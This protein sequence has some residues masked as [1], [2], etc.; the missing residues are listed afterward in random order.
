[1]AIDGIETGAFGGS[2]CLS[3]LESPLHA[4]DVNHIPIPDAVFFSVAMGIS[5]NQPNP[6]GEV[7]P[8]KGLT[9]FY[10]QGSDVIGG[11]PTKFTANGVASVGFGPWGQSLKMISGSVYP[12]GKYLCNVGCVIN[13]DLTTGTALAFRNGVINPGTA[14]YALNF[15]IQIVS[16][17]GVISSITPPA[18]DK[19]H[20]AGY[21]GAILPETVGIVPQT[22]FTFTATTQFQIQIIAT[23]PNP[24]FPFAFQ[25]NVGGLQVKGS[26]GITMGIEWAGQRTGN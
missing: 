8:G 11:L 4:R 21:Q 5:G 26:C 1:M 24:G 20:D 7:N 25:P 6:F 19:Q 18:V 9:A 2:D 15:A 14:P 16:P 22:A 17:S 10:S 23:F 12:K 3:F 13:N